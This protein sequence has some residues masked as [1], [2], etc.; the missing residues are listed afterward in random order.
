MYSTVSK[1]VFITLYERATEKL[2]A[3]Y[4]TPKKTEERKLKEGQSNETST[5]R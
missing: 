1:Q 5:K 4:P 3:Q 2:A